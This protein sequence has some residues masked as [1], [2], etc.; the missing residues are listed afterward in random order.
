MASAPV[1]PSPP[2]APQYPPPGPVVNMPPNLWMILKWASLGLG[3]LL[4]L[5]AVVLE[6]VHAPALAA[7][8]CFFAIGARIMQAEEHRGK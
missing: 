7:M 4:V 5:I 3:G 1:Q 2:P 8:G 6:S